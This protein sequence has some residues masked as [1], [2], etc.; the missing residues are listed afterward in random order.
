MDDY[1]DDGFEAASPTR[2]GGSDSDAAAKIQARYRGNRVRQAQAKAAQRRSQKLLLARQQSYKAAEPK[3]R[4]ELPRSSRPRLSQKGPIPFLPNIDR[5]P[6]ERDPLR[7]ELS[8]PALGGGGASGPGV[9][10]SGSPQ[11]DQTELLAS[12][13]LSVAV[14]QEAQAQENLRRVRARIQRQMRKVQSESAIEKSRTRKLALAKAAKIEMDKLVGRDL[15]AR[16]KSDE[17]PKATDEEVRKLS[18]LLNQ[19]LQIF[20]PDARNFF[21]LFKH[22]DVDGSRRV[23]FNELSRLIREQ[24]KVSTKE[25]PELRLMALWKVLDENASGFID[26]G[27]LSRFMRIGRPAGGL[28]NR[29]KKV[30]ENK[31]TAALQRKLEAQRSGKTLLKALNTNNIV[32]ASEAEVKELSVKFNKRLAEVRPRDAT[33]GNNFYRLFKH[34]DVDNS[35][36]ISFT[37]FAQ[38]VRTDLLMD[39]DALPKPRLQSLWRALDENESGYICAGEFGRFMRISADTAPL[40]PVMEAREKQRAEEVAERDR[41]SAMWK[42]RAARRA[43]EKAEALAREAA[44]LEAALAAVTAGANESKSGSGSMLPPI[45]GMGH[46]QALE[47]LKRDQEKLSRKPALGRGS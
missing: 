14:M 39:R 6:G 1:A 15:T 40:D 41:N 11:H 21:V 43:H 37:E 19:Q 22:I 42:A 46:T 34:M 33:S 4:R 8:L 25:M 16:L 30:M 24:L 45:N 29:I 10:E 18:E 12:E 20:H 17:I 13:Q 32:K 44:A 27:E 36:R 31:A 5:S 3:A 2:F 9:S 26:A 28:G 23:S 38:M 47:I 35:G 7:R